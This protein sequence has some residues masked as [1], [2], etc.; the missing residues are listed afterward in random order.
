MLVKLGRW[1]RAAGFDTVIAKGGSSD[2]RLIEQALA[3]ERWLLTRDRHMTEFRD[4]TRCVVHLETEGFEAWA[5]ELVERLGVDWL[6]APF[7]RCMVCNVGLIPAPEE[8][9]D[10][11]PW[12]GRGCNGPLRLCPDC[13][14]LYWQ[15]GHVQRMRAQLECF[16][17]IKGSKGINRPKS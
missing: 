11:L 16:A 14:R 2:R 17:S 6:H 15:G 3:E 12:E 5:H 7:S 10:R 1:L 8:A 4:A 9:R 13:N